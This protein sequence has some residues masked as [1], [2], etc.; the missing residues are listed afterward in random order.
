MGLINIIESGRNRHKGHQR[1][2]YVKGLVVQE[3]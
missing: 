2:H 3:T 1:S